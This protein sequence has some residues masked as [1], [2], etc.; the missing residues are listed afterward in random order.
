MLPLFALLREIAEPTPF[1]LSIFPSLEI[2]S[3]WGTVTTIIPSGTQKVLPTLVERKCSIGSSPLTSSMTLTYLRFSTAS[4]AVAPLLTAPFLPPLLLLG[5][6]SR[7][8]F[9]LPTNSTNRP[10]LSDL[11]P[12]Q[13]S[14]SF[15]FQKARWD[16]FALCFDSH[17]LSAEEYSFLSL[18]SAAALFTS[19]ILKAFFTIWCSGQT[20]LFLFILAKAALAYFP[21]ALSLAL[22]PPFSLQQAHYV[23]VFSAEAC[24]I[25]QALCWSLQ[26][27][28]VCHF[29]S[30]LL[31]SDS[32]SVLAALFSPPSFL[33]SQILLQIWQELSS[34]YSCSIRLQW[35]PRHS[36]LPGNKAAD[37][38]ARWGALFVSLQSLVALSLVSTLIFSQTGGVLFFDTQVSS[39]ST[40][41]LV[42]LCPA[43][44][45]LSRLRCNGHS[46]LLSLSL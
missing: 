25:L 23:Q 10:S 3:F 28:Q 36:F 18:S 43:P 35:F 44:S 32:R 40:E 29:F 41:E 42:L 21:T 1:L 13:T 27:P 37:E 34:L 22:R 4:R 38:L 14:P 15:N 2:F 45:V 16:D 12:Q 20:A 11:L 33:L 5:G 39:I 9:S 17:C 46:L 30:L 19:L 8:G 26:L 24:A 7:P 6:A 31:L